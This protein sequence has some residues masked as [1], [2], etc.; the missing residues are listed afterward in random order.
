MF[1]R[2][3]PSHLPRHTLDDAPPI[4][5]SA[6]ALGRQGRRALAH[7]ESMAY[8]QS[9]QACPSQVGS[10]REVH[11]LLAFA[12]TKKTLRQL[13]KI[14]RGSLWA[15]RA[16][17]NGGHCHVNWRLVS[18]PLELGGL[19]VRDL[20]RVGLALRLRWLWLSRTDE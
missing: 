10:L 6:T 11:Q 3:A 15:G 14:Q 12:P 5:R 9:R 16:V 8:E 17:A 7:L 20:E 19:G 2:C 18:R 13:E 1:D 4:R